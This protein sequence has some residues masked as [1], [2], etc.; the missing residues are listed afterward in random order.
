LGNWEV[1]DSAVM[2]KW[3]RLL[4]MVAN[5]KARFSGD[6]IFKLVPIW[7]KCINVIG[8]CAEK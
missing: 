7:D 3:K 5:S 4:V 2:K 8:D 6:G 1:A